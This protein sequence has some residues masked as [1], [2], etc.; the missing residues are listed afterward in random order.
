MSTVRSVR[1]STIAWSLAALAPFL[2]LVVVRPW[3]PSAFPVWDYADM[4][5]LLRPARTLGSAFAALVHFTRADGRANYLTYLQLAATWRVAGDNPVAWQWQRAILMLVSGCLCVW[6]IRRL[7]GTAIAAATAGLLVTLAVPSTEGW[8]FIMGEPLAIIL[9][10]AMVLVGADYPTAAHWRGRAVGIAIL[11]A[12]VML[13][14]EVVGVCLPAIVFFIVC[15]SSEHGFGRPKF[16]PR[17]RLLAALL[18][19]VLIA[20]AWSVRTALAGA[21]ST[22]Y[23]MSFGHSTADAG[24]IATLFQAML[25]PDRFSSA[26][27][28]SDLYPANFAFLALLIVGLLSSAT[29]AAAH[30]DFWSWSVGLLSFPVIGAL[31]Y[32]LWPRYSAFY[33]L[34]FFAGSVGLMAVA[35]T[36]IQRQHPGGRWVV[37]ILGSVSVLYTAAV[38]RRTVEYKRAI[39]NIAAAIVHR[40]PR[41]PPLDTLFMVVPRRGGRRWPVTAD[42]LRHYARALQ[43]P[44]PAIPVMRDAPCEEIISRL[45]HPLGGNAVLNDQNPCGPLPA[46]TIDWAAVMAYRDPWS[47]RVRYDTVAVQ[48]LAPNWN[49]RH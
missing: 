41:E 31:T 2:S 7:G 4:L 11:A 47:W 40:L 27:V 18:S 49:T 42:E 8:L 21:A 14:K 15:W 9:L 37:A 28:A 26:G 1:E 3:T 30:R 20:E 24:T 48:I 19:I 17:E 35:A 43:I 36:E 12:L 29:R 25:L 22:A 5:P 13:S 44:D 33:G 16:G 38:S 45:R 10:L 32:A 34:P 46:V 23:A 39:A 6:V